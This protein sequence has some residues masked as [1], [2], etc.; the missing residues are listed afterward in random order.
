VPAALTRAPQEFPLTLAI[1][2]QRTPV[3][4]SSSFKESLLSFLLGNFAQFGMGLSAYWLYSRG[5]LS[6]NKDNGN[7]VVKFIG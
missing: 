6:L 5:L 3:P 4:S 7:N 2:C 1:T